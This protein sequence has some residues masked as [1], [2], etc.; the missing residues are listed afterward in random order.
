VKE[1]E[2]RRRRRKRR[3]KK[4]KKR[5]GGGRKR[6][7]RATWL[8]PRRATWRCSSFPLNHKLIR[9]LIHWLLSFLSLLFQWLLDLQ[10][11]VE[12]FQWEKIDFILSSSLSSLSLLF[13]FLSD[14]PLFS[15]DVIFL[16]KEIR[17]A[18][19][20]FCGRVCS[21]QQAS[22]FPHLPC[23][24]ASGLV[25][26]QPFGSLDLW[27]SDCGTEF[28]NLWFASLVISPFEKWFRAILK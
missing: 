6:R 28:P 13:L 3:K 21:A 20:T 14:F 26:L 18:W 1:E 4:E 16:G 19:G 8:E 27:E 2:E 22:A 25:E 9:W 23:R 5:E 17:E 11:G 10:V 15:L 7:R 12:R 24:L